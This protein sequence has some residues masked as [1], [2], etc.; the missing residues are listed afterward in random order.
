MT[1]LQLKRFEELNSL[2]VVWLSKLSGNPMVR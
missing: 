1:A 2:A